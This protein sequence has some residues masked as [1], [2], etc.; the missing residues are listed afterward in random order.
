MPDMRN[1][2]LAIME[3]LDVEV[4]PLDS[5]FGIDEE[6]LPSDDI[7]DRAGELRLAWAAAADWNASINFLR[8]RRRRLVKT[9]LTRAAVVA[10]VATGVGIAWRLQRSALLEPAIPAAKPAATA[11]VPGPP[12]KAIPSPPPQIQAPAQFVARSPQGPVLPR[13]LQEPIQ[14]LSRQPVQPSP[15]TAGRAAPP[16]VVLRRVPEPARPPSPA[17]PLTSSTSGS[18]PVPGPTVP[19][20]GRRAPPEDVP[21]PFEATLGTILYGADRK[22]AIIDGRI[23]Q[24]GDDVRGFRVVEITPNSVL[25]RDRQGRLRQLALGDAAK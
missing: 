1:M 7:H 22:L 19:T 21:L 14:Q 3:R 5:L 18:R 13:P 24:V 20:P 11:T 12:P 16:P 23:V 25:L 2:T 4:E 15:A 9:V 17:E 6:H 10:G 8:E